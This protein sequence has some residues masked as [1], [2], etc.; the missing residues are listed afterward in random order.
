[1]RY[2]HHQTAERHQRILDEASRLFRARGFTGASIGDVM[3]ASGLTH[4]GFYAH[5]ESK[6]ALACA[7]LEHA[8]SSMLEAEVQH[9][10]DA[11]S[12]A[13]ADFLSRY[14]SATHRDHPEEGCPMAALVIDVARESAVR[15]TFTDR[16]KAMLTTLG[17]HLPWKMG[18]A[19]ERQVM[20]FTAA[21]VGAVV[22]ARAVDDPKLS[23]AI[24]AS[25]REEL[26]AR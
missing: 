19:K 5:F 2:P 21:M 20:H 8:M 22:L 10:K 4:G 25:V 13:K 6:E 26:L 1:M 3:K 17:E 11:G 9:M 12:N 23:E 15:S 18:R 24:L 7:S 14:L 16:F